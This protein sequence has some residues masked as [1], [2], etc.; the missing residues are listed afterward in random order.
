M[1]KEM[2][3]YSA[4]RLIFFVGAVLLPI[5]ALCQAPVLKTTI[6]KN[7]LLIGEQL[8]LKVKAEVS[9]KDYIVNWFVLPDTPGHFDVIDP[10]K[11]DTTGSGSNTILQQVIT[12]TSFDSGSWTTPPFAVSFKQVV[13]GNI[14]TLYA[15]SMPVAVSF[16][17]DT[18]MQLKDI[19]PIFDVQD[20]WPLWY[21]LAGAGVVLLLVLIG[22]L[23]YFYLARK[24]AKDV[25]GE[26]LGAYNEAM[27]ALAKLPQPDAEKADSVKLYYTRLS[28]IVKHYLSRKHGASN[29]MQTTDELLVHVS[30]IYPQREVVSILASLL[31]SSDAVKF[32]KYLPEAA[33]N[34]ESLHRA[35]KSIEQMEQSQILP[36]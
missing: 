4:S 30:A 21:Y 9:L 28:A 32:A 6:T 8:Q 20:K 31:R 25:S 12:L 15:D 34:M 22:V 26:G 7:Q 35:K 16:A 24:K 18:S 14:T 17:A 5:A 33:E 27:A 29:H 2:K 3:R 19:K 11:L 13:T 23:I 1:M 36:N 10:G